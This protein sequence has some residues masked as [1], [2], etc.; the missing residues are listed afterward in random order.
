MTALFTKASRSGAV[1]AFLVLAVVVGGA[2]AQNGKRKT[3]GSDI[4]VAKT[5]ADYEDANYST[6]QAAVNAARPGQVI[7][8]L[9][10]ETYEG[11]VTIDGRDVS[12]W[13]GVTGGKNGITIRY[14][15]VGG[16][17]GAA[18]NHPRPTIRYRDINN[19]HPRNS[20]EA[21][22]DNELTGAGNFETNGALRVLRAK[23]VTIEGIA[24]DG[25]GSFAFGATGVW[26]PKSG[27]DC[28]PLFHGNAAIT[29]A[30]AGQ[31]TIRDCDLKNAYF[32]INVK[33]R[34]TGG[35][36]GNPNVADRD[37]TVP[38]SNFG[39]VGG[40]L[41]EYN[42]INNN[43]VGLFFESAWDLGSTVRYNLIYGNKIGNRPSSFPD[44][45]KNNQ[46]AGAFLFKD[47]YLSPIA[48]YN[49][50]LYDN[51]GNF[52][53]H[54][55]AGGQH[56]IFNNIFSKSNP[57]QNPG[58]DH[59]SLD[60]KFPFRMNNCLFSIDATKVQAQCQT[61]Y[62]CAANSAIAPGG[63]FVA[64]LQ[65]NAAFPQV[66]G[67]QTNITN[68][69]N[70]NASQPERQNIVS[71]GYVFT[72]MKGANNTNITI[73]ATNEIRWL[74]TEGGTVGQGNQTS[75]LPTLFKSLTPTSA[76]FLV[77][78]WDNELV[79]RYIKNKGWAAAG[80]RNND[81]SIADL[82]AIP[83]TG[84]RQTTVARI[85]P[86]AVVILSGGGANAA[87]KFSLKVD[88]GTLNNPKIKLLRWIAPIPTNT[89]ENEGDGTSQTNPTG[90]NWPQR[91]R[92]IAQN[93]ISTITNTS[94]VTVGNNSFNFT[95]GKT[96]V[97][98][99][100]FFEIIVEGT[101]ANGNAVAS[102]VGFLPYRELQYFLDITVHNGD[103]TTALTTVKA[104]EPYRI[105]V[106]T[107]CAQ[108]VTPCPSTLSEIE[109]SLLS[110]PTAFIRN[111]ANGDTLS[112]ERNVAF[113]KNYSG[114]YFSVAGP[115]TIFGSGTAI[116][117][118]NRVSFIGTLDLT[119]KP[120]APA[121]AVFTD[122]ISL[123]QLGSAP[124]PVI[125]RG[126]DRPV[127]VEVQ[128]RFGN[129]VDT[130]V[131][132]TV[133]VNPANPAVTTDC[134]TCGDVGASS[135]NMT[136]K[137]ASTSASTGQV[138]FNAKAV[139]G[140]TGQT[141][142]MTATV[143]GIS[144]QSDKEN[145]GRLRL[146][147][148]LDRF[149]VFYSDNGPSKQWQTYFDPSVII[150]KN[151]GEWEQIT[152]K[153]VVGD[154]VV[155]SRRSEFVLVSPSDNNLI[156]SATQGGAAATIFPLTSGVATFWVSTAP[157]TDRDIVNAGIN[158]YALNTNDPNDL[159]ASISSGGRENINFTKLSTSIKY[160]VVYGDGQ[161][162]PDSLK[163]VY[164]EGGA[165]L[166]SAGAKPTRVTLTWGGVELSASAGAIEVIDDVTLRVN[167]LTVAAGSKPTG[168][169]SIA[170]VGRG[171][172]TVYGGSAGA[173]AVENGFDV[174]DGVGP[175]L[176][177]GDEGDGAG[178]SGPRIYDNSD[179]NEVDTLSVT[180]S[181]DIN[182]SG[183]KTLLYAAG[184]AEPT[185]L[186]G[187]RL[188]VIEVLGAGPTY[189]LVV[190]PQGGGA[191]PVVNGWIKLDYEG[192]A[193]VTDMAG[194]QS[195]GVIPDNKPNAANRWVQLKPYEL[196]PEVRSAW[197]TGN[198]AVG[199]PD[200][201]YVV[202]NKTVRPDWFVDSEGT[203]GTVNFGT[204]ITINAGN[205]N[206]LFELRGDT[207]V[208]DLL[209]AA[210]A[211]AST[212]AP[213]RTTGDI[214]YSFSYQSGKDWSTTRGTGA[215]AAKDRAAPVLARPATLKTGS[216]KSDGSFNQ[217]TLIV[218][219]SEQISA[220]S[221]GG[222]NGDPL[223]LKTKGG[224][225]DRFGEL[226]PGL[227]LN[228][229]V[230]Y[231][232]T[233]GYY[234]ARYVVDPDFD[235]DNYPEPG[236]SVQIYKFADVGDNQE[237]S[238]VQRDENNKWQ[239]LVVDRAANW[240]VKIKRNP[241]TAD[242]SGSKDMEIEFSPNAR[243]VT[244]AAVKTKITIFDN[245]GSRVVDT[246]VD[247]S[248]NPAVKKVTFKW[249]GENMKGRLVGTGSY[250][251]KAT[252]ESKAEG[253]SKADVYKVPPQMLGVVRGKQ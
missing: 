240:T 136:Q 165:P 77:P 220:A 117:S 38:L 209:I 95:T 14:V 206:D 121:K 135:A 76:D 223:R 188:D 30:V 148:A 80:I 144:N 116:V 110:G 192:T 62:N 41:F 218:Y 12:P 201:A 13:A 200:Y 100:G 139:S 235:I 72:S 217:D 107:R 231:D 11:Q 16:A 170:G 61:N 162:R 53:G 82:G 9:D 204:S 5:M 203:N 66:Q 87:A 54:W 214:E 133:S 98:K 58:N 225:G 236:D 191:N 125:N 228:G 34:N 132:V 141:F 146:G 33:D 123:A 131:Q 93:A 17:A 19:T 78:D 232:R 1:A 242:A 226:Q 102:D 185:G 49:N 177:N 251:L 39:L 195:G 129:A 84:V 150:D 234:I 215:T 103:N 124:A 101:D 32:G 85:M 175:L 197:Y 64:A 211:I 207:L 55:Q 40:H 155:T 109:Y 96:V 86:T 221:A 71:P 68:C 249:R 167:S 21:Q 25:G 168:Y 18:W 213:I 180:I 45:E 81:G 196:T 233:S 237:P 42:K 248:A 31:V 145:I 159:D 176:A 105:R 238:N 186:T 210:P 48:I 91:M 194:T 202:F 119:V 161:G 182:V 169:T 208:V 181:E 115:E 164:Q 67:T 99:Y 23:G 216:P 143:A 187:T 160:A 172:V 43:V 198:N 57:S 222:A 20:S 219:F 65:D 166:S 60:G 244:T 224:A 106:A 69:S 134:P 171:L 138:T 130:A 59:M 152:V 63:C 154:T 184:P 50:T 178:S 227:R 74:Q 51:T 15:P 122:P 36:F 104:G 8:I 27:G 126:V 88:N 193:V 47:M 7:E 229:G 22:Q 73:P 24:V 3:P 37:S 127:I 245:I 253:D 75:T 89:L 52:C 250:L 44:V 108:G 10:T 156:F 90:G 2:F 79:T 183:L 252:C 189:K 137:T 4:C 35:V 92:P 246:T 56:L 6:I 29:L 243:G 163:I 46:N 241:F 199:K 147:R 113:P 97:P 114:Y 120:G 212:T 239:P 174:Y 140:A 70:P 83:S 157:G 28:S 190:K 230:D 128:D 158:V 111:S 173:D 149:E 94:A 151:V 118:N 153:V 142:D 247:N 26:C 179:N 205:I 112:Y